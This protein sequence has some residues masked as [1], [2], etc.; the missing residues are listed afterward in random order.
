MM[1]RNLPTS[2]G[3]RHPGGTVASPGIRRT[4]RL[5]LPVGTVLL[6][7][8]WQLRFWPYTVDD[9]FIS[10][11]YAT[12]LSSGRGLVYNPGER[13]EGYSNFLWVVWVAFAVHSGWD[14]VLSTKIVGALSGVAAIALVGLV[15]GARASLRRWGAPVLLAAQGGVALWSVAGL[16]TSLFLA[17]LLL[18]ALLVSRRRREWIAPGVLLVLIRPEGLFYA[19]VLFGVRLVGRRDRAVWG[20]AALFLCATL[21]Y[22]AWRL[23]YYGDVFPNTYYAKAAGSAPE[24]HYLWWYVQKVL[25]CG[26]LLPLAAVGFLKRSIPRLHLA[27]IGVNIASVLSVG[28]DWMPSFRLLLPTTALILVAACGGA[29]ALPRRTRALATTGLCLLGAWYLAYAGLTSFRVRESARGYA[30]AHLP[31]AMA[32]KDGAPADSWVALMDIGMIGYYSGLNVLDIT[33][34]TDPVIARAG[35]GMLAKRVDV[36]YILDRNPLHIVLVSSA[37]PRS[38]RFR[39]PHPMDKRLFRNDR[40]TAAY[41][42][43]TAFDYYGDGREP[44]YYL[45]LFRRSADYLTR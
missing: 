31:L 36:G 1:P 43:V 35:G 26:L 44:G 3:P 15:S 21:P 7:F 42:F 39:M 2:E 23:S 29:A 30:R 25:G 9:A 10:Y 6:L 11:R 32:L 19:L 34:L 18:S 14:P 33:G 4:L 5:A 28:G 13:V 40:F 24:P 22:A 41:A 37:D 45:C 27:L 12:N 17:L 8:G 20:E 16:E 38:G